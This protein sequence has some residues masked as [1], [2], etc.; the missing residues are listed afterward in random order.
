MGMLE[1]TVL[2]LI[3]ERKNMSA[4]KIHPDMKL[5]AS[6]YGGIVSGLA[7]YLIGVVSK[8]RGPMF[9]SAFNPLS[10]GIGVV[11]SVVIVLG[12]YLVL[13]GQS[14]DNRGQFPPNAGC[15]KTMVEVDEQMVLTPDNNQV[16]RQP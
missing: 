15:A 2:A 16:L 10:M 6:I 13:W 14:K 8:E 12:I 11:G 7:Y 9:V 5:L 4:W 1:A 3:C